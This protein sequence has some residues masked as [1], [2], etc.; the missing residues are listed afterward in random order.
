MKT[1]SKISV[2]IF[3]NGTLALVF[4]G[5]VAAFCSAINIPNQKLTASQNTSAF[6]VNGH[7]SV[8]SPAVPTI[9]SDQMLSFA[10]RVGYQR[11]IEEVYW[12][13]R[14]WPEANAGGSPTV[15]G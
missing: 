11:V 1:K 9:R 14:I 6:G 3:C 13:H 5:A 8:S 7:E 2:Y 4:L 10:E 15:G 12:R